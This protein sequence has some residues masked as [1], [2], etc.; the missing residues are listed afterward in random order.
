MVFWEKLFVCVTLGL[1][2]AIVLANQLYVYLRFRK[3]KCNK[4]KSKS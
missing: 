3:D 1:V 4:S 2:I